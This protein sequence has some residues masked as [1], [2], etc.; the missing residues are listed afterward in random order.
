M[1]LRETENVT[2]L[3]TIRIDVEE[4]RRKGLKLRVATFCSIVC[5]KRCN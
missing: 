1:G 2:R 4:R 3:S 5:L